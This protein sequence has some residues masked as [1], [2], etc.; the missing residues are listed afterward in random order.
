MLVGCGDQPFPPR[1]GGW[2]R[3]SAFRRDLVRLDA[4][5]VTFPTEPPGRAR[6]IATVWDNFAF[7]LH[8][9][10]TDEETIFWPALRTLGVS[11]GLTEELRAEHARMVVALEVAERQMERFQAD[12]R[13]GTA[14]RPG[15]GSSSWPWC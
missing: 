13:V 6:A 12:P 8:H 14:P 11:D 10:H 5:L 7:Q 4:A 3:R 9:H 15:R 1:S 2:G